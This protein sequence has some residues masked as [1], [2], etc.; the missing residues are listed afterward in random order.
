MKLVLKPR[1]IVGIEDRV[2]VIGRRQKE[3][4]RAKEGKSIILSTK[5]VDGQCGKR[6]RMRN[7]K[8][9]RRKPIIPPFERGDQWMRG[10]NFWTGSKGM[11]GIYKRIA[12]ASR[13]LDVK[14]K[15]I[16]KVRRRTK[17]IT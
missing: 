16:V 15:V 11:V 12:K 4:E 7:R 5:R 1:N 17:K 2:R 3:M 13:G 6:N 8:T 10:G 14:V 9:K